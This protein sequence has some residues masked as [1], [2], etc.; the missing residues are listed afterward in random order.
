V[1]D[2]HKIVLGE[3]DFAEESSAS[4]GVTASNPPAAAIAQANDPTP[5]PS[6]NPLP[7]VTRGVPTRVEDTIAARPSQLAQTGAGAGWLTNPG[8]ELLVASAIGVVLAWVVTQVL[9]IAEIHVTTRTGSNAVTGLWTGVVGIMFGGTLLAFD[10]A[11]AGAWEI[12][13]TR[14]AKAA[15][16]MF[17]AAF[18]AGYIG[19]VIYFQI[20]KGVIEEA[21][22]SGSFSDNDVQL[23]LARGLGWAL[24]GIG[25]GGTIGLLSKSRQRAINGALGG[26]LGGAAGGVVFQFVGV[27]LGAGVG[28]SRLLGLIGI[29]ALI[30]L[31]TRAVEAARREAWLQVLS[32]GMAG[33]E[34]ILYHAVTRLGSTPA[35]EIF[36][37]K[38]SAIAKVHA[39]IEDRGTQRVVTAMPDAPVFVNQAPVNVQVL[40]NGDQV[41]VGNTVLGY[42][43]R[44]IAAPAA[45]G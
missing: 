4:V 31:A 6:N 44:A 18:V 8:R 24:F 14:F 22:R 19:N 30:A 1:V 29:G 23:Y 13:G 28:M 3:D 34:F 16:P 26:A 21:F 37:L 32:G 42:S 20:V 38:D 43:E 7:A 41:Q 40:R 36:L 17:G 25:I 39:Q 27:N 35:C 5:A 33:K 15:A 45:Y 12:A 11:V 9:G 2:R 10:S